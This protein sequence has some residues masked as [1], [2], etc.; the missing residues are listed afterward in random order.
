MCGI[1]MGQQVGSKD[2]DKYFI[3]LHII[4]DAKDSYFCIILR[5][6]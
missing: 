3:V 6:S 4:Y 2:D 1:N 5:D